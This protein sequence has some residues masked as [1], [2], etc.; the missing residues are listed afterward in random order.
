MSVVAAEE[1]AETS[2]EPTVVQCDARKIG[3]DYTQDPDAAYSSRD[4]A[5]AA[6]SEE[7]CERLCT[8]SEVEAY[9]EPR[10]Y[11]GWT[12]DSWGYNGADGWVE[13]SETDG[14]AVGAYCCG[15]YRTRL[16]DCS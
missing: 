4:T 3:G 13:W 9:P 2:G 16:S 14:E 7:G 15:M 1:A 6:C 10:L 12:S 11:A 5:E 8:K